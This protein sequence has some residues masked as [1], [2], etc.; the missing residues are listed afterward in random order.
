MELA[1]FASTRS[2]VTTVTA[3]GA[4]DLSTRSDVS[5]FLS[6]QLDRGNHRLLLDM[7]SVT[8]LSCAGLS[9]LLA[10]EHRARRG[11]GWL[12]LIGTDKRVTRRVLELTGT[13]TVLGTTCSSIASPP[14]VAATSGPTP[15]S[16]HVES[17]RAEGAASL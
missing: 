14:A 15:P 8:F 12:R 4:L 10:V 7:S 2:G 17:S 9:A 5:T 16:A 1:L 11:G 3:T 13:H 6:G